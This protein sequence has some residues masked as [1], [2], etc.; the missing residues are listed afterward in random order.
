MYWAWARQRDQRRLLQ[1]IGP[2]LLIE[3]GEIVGRVKDA[4]ISGNVYDLLRQVE[5]VSSER[6]WVD[7]NSLMPYVLLPDMNVVAG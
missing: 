4:S 5:A 7:G 3:H 6:V 1:R 2:G